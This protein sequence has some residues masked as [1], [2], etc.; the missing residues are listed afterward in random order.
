MRRE[1]RLKGGEKSR[2]RWSLPRERDWA[3]HSS[4]DKSRMTT[5]A[6]SPANWTVTKAERRHSPIHMPITI[7]MNSVSFPKSEILSHL[8]ATSHNCGADIST[9]AA[10][11]T[12]VRNRRFTCQA[13]Q[14][15]LQPGAAC[16]RVCPRKPSTCGCLT[17]SEAAPKSMAFRVK[18]Q[19]CAGENCH[20]FAS[21]RPRCHRIC[22]SLPS[23]KS[24]LHFP[25]LTAETERRLRPPR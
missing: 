24:A 10:S 2:R 1:V 19:V 25:E 23:R 18:F 9:T 21:E 22:A 3:A 14:K 13:Y 7:S 5:D 6:T 8:S 16:S 20:N 11:E 12:K 17:N 15:V 4:A